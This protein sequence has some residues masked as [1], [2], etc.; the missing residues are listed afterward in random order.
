MSS[1]RLKVRGSLPGHPRQNEENSKI[2]GIAPT[3]GMHLLCT[4]YM[5]SGNNANF[6]DINFLSF[7]LND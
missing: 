7:L 1:Q 5:L 3:D 4:L 2:Q 6:S